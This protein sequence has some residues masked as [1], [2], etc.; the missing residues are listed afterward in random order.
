MVILSLPGSYIN[1]GRSDAVPVFSLTI[2]ISS[3]VVNCPK[4]YDLATC[5]SVHKEAGRK[6]TRAHSSLRWIK[7]NLD[8]LSVTF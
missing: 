8:G 5:G 4:K 2:H 3:T 6:Q 7:V 1:P